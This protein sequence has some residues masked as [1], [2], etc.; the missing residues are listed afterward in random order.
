VRLFTIPLS[1]FMQSLQIR[2]PA[3]PRR[4]NVT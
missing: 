1:I 4:A 3:M 2:L